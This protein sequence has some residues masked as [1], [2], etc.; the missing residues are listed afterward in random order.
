LKN[1][2][3]RA[4]F[5]QRAKVVPIQLKEDTNGNSLINYDYTGGI[6]CCPA[7]DMP[8]GRA[9]DTSSYHY[10]FILLGSKPFPVCPNPWID[11][12]IIDVYIHCSKYI[13]FSSSFKE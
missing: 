3:K 11:S 12:S 10:K 4:S 8:N 13:H 7:N 1:T 9:H 5:N 2:P 6:L